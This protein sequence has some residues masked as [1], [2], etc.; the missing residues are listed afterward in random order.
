MTEEK[1]PEVQKH[2]IH[3]ELDSTGKS[4]VDGPF[5]DPFV[6]WGLLGLAITTFVKTLTAPQIEVPRSLPPWAM[7]NLKS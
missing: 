3:I 4:L 7:K 2:Y 5:K 6:F 1:K